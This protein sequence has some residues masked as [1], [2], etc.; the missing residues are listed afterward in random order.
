MRYKRNISRWK[1]IPFGKKLFLLSV[2]SF[3]VFGIVF[4]IRTIVLTWIAVI[5]P[6]V[7]WA[8]LAGVEYISIVC[9]ITLLIAGILSPMFPKA[10]RIAW[11][12]RR[13]ILDPAYGNPLN[14]LEG[15]RL[16]TVRCKKSDAT[17]EQF[18]LKIQTNGFT[19]KEI[20]GLAPAISPALT[21]N[22]RNYAVKS[23]E[24]D[25]A[26]NFIDFVIEDVTLDYRIQFTSVDDMYPPSNT[27]LLIDKRTVIDLTVSG[28]IL[29][30]AKTRSGKTTGII[31]ILLQV[32]LC[33]PDRYG[34]DIN[35]IDPK[36]AELSRLP[37]VITVDEDGGGRAILA[38]VKRF[39]DRMTER[40]NILNILSEVDGNAVHWWE[41]AMHPSFLVLDEFVAL[42]TL[43]PQRADKNDPD[44]CLAAF[45]ALLKRIITMGA[46][47][48]CYVIIS[49]AEASVEEGG[50][51]SMLRSAM[52]TKILFRPTKSEAS[53]LWRAEKLENLPDKTYQPGDAWF[54]ST[55]GVHDE[56]SFVRF[57]QMNFPIY[58]ELGRLLKEYYSG[59]GASGEAE[60]EPP[61]RPAESGPT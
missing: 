6:R 59:T 5:I 21:G 49:I 26:H 15:Q 35:I 50:L 4:A 39:A 34:S 2:L 41:A 47:A 60:R 42:R 32:L 13:M 56:V 40:Q 12:V 31:D 30:A 1:F 7:V 61:S 54:S 8:Y 20:S 14:L 33:G 58:K 51:P 18:I 48:G 16:P 52:T 27:K 46:S 10:G 19:P 38:A 45:D 3:V 9:G 37:H 43:F 23:I 36:R 28:S 53:L 57:P 11:S 24:E 22:L 17:Q 29:I 55:D 44:Y 25:T